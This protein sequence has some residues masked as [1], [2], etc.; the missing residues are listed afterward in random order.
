M[1]NFA[2][3]LQQLPK[4]NTSTSSIYSGSFTPF[5]VQVKFDIC[6]FEGQIDVDVVDKL[7][8][9]LGGYFFVYDFP[10]GKRLPFLFSNLSPISRT[11]GKPTMSRRMK[12]RPH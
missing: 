2:Q 9:L 5:K 3:I 7:L 10:N 11:G 12:L 1:E 8:N 6:I 4:G